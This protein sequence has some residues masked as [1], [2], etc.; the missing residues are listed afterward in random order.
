MSLST[1]IPRAQIS[2]RLV[3]DMHEMIPL[4]FLPAGHSAAVGQLIGGQNDIH[5]L[6]EL[7]LRGGAQIEMVQPGSPC[8]IRLDGQKFC[9]RAD[10]ALQVSVHGGSPA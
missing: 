7:G 2:L 5:R 6:E 8:I 4:E 1:F 3:R 10:D 9:F